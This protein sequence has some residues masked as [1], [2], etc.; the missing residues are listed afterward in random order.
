MRWNEILREDSESELVAQILTVLEFLRNRDHNKK[1]LPQHSTTGFINMVNNMNNGT[2]GRLTYELLD[3][4][5]NSDQTV[6]G[7]ITS[8]DKQ[9]ISL[10]SFGDEPGAPE[11][12]SD[13]PSGGSAKDPTSIV[14]A[15]AK[16]AAANR[17]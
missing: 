3:Q 7:L 4:I 11:E 10:K 13:E 8:M 14:N 9:N 6:G 15:M 2:G 17:S 1:L 16:K 5:K 12:P